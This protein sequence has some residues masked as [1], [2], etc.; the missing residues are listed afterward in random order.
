MG[1]LTVST[2][3]ILT[4]RE[5]AALL[6]VNTATLRRLPVPYLPIGSGS[7][8]PRRRYLRES[9]LAWAKAQEVES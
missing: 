6:K 2:A 4:P 8:R 1:R 3:P 5:C 9:V 7:R